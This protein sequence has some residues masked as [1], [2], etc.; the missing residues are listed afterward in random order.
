MDSNWRSELKDMLSRLQ[1]ELENV[2]SEY[3][4]D[5]EALERRY[6]SEIGA[7]RQAL[8]GVQAALGES[9][10][11]E[12]ATPMAHK[13]DEATLSPPREELDSTI[14]S[15]GFG[16]ESL[17]TSSE[18]TET[19]TEGFSVRHEIE[20]LLSEF[21]PDQDVTQGEIRRELERRFPEHKASLQASTISS[22]LRRI[23]KAGD[24]VKVYEGTG[25]EPN[26]YRLPDHDD[27]NNQKELSELRE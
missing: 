25:S 3:Q 6:E 10:E 24:L 11:L 17:T 8:R 5:K 21:Q 26:I 20:T 12:A 2:D 19:A 1:S 22:A 16:R 7:L 14:H 4:R 23:A 18:Q 15:N 13:T 9:R 27:I